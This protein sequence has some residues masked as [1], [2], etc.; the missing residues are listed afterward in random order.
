MESVERT[1]AMTTRRSDISGSS[2]PITPRQ[3]HPTLQPI[4]RKFADRASIALIG[5]RGAGKKS[6]GFITASQLGRRFVNEGLCFE[7]ATGLSKSAYLQ[8]HGKRDFQARSLQVFKRMLQDNEYDCVIDCGM[9]SVA[10]EAQELLRHYA[11]NHPVIHI[12][13]NFDHIAR[14]L[15]LNTQ[16]AKHLK[17]AD[18]R[19]RLCS[20]L[21]FYNVYDSTSIAETEI[22]VHDFKPTSPFVL[23][24]IK[25][26]VQNYV[27]FI[28]NRHS[29]DLSSPFSLSAL[30][31]ELKTRSY[32]TF[33]RL[34]SLIKESAPFDQTDSGEDAVELCI[35]TWRP[36]ITN[37][38]SKWVSML[39]RWLGVRIIVSIVREGLD[40]SKSAH[41]AYCELMN[42]VLRLGVD[43]ITIDMTL[44]E[45]FQT[46][47]L[48]SRGQTKAIAYLHF[49]NH[50]SKTWLDPE[51]VK[52]C[53]EAQRLGY[54]L[55]KLTQFA[56][57][58]QDNHQ[59]LHFATSISQS[60][61][62]P[63]IAY[64]LGYLGRTTKVFNQTLTPI[65]RFEADC[66]SYHEDTPE[67]A[68]W[69]RQICAALFQ[70]FEY[71]PLHFHVIGQ[72]VA[73]SRT[74]A[75][76]NAAFQLYG[77]RHSFSYREVSSFDDVLTFA[78]DPFFGGSAISYPYKE[79][80]FKA[81]VGVSPHASVIGSINTIMPLRQIPANKTDIL[82]EQAA[83]RNRGGTM[84]GL[85]GDNSDWES[86]Y[87]NVRRKLSPRNAAAS[88]KNVGLVL[89]AGGSS[90]STVYALLLLGCTTVY[91][92]NRTRANAV[93]VADHFNAWCRTQESYVGRASVQTL[94]MDNTQWP[95][96]V[97]LPTIIISCVPT[98]STLFG[99]HEKPL[100]IPEAWLGSLAGGVVADVSLLSRPGFSDT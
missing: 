62:I 47:L 24:N 42:H 23:Q 60:L 78:N 88:S 58:R 90:R 82:S 6:L 26:D 61:A 70:C 73:F 71:D 86:I 20:N 84:T 31:P 17:E 1:H 5:V 74:P 41:I 67:A 65:K 64:N 35:D 25:I 55:I 66:T 13:R 50:H 51:R 21:E 59:V 99:R 22:S 48:L 40:A 63:V 15:Q 28:L 81:C 95:Q 98:I 77:M 16:Q 79:L 76:Y 49:E 56:A 54:D 11:L 72:H 38:I 12:V 89:G 91:I 43:Y 39:R 93:R 75:M 52:L 80:A 44:P 92:C 14:H 96:D 29:T 33:Y 69:L 53:H 34:S 30:P 36:D 4:I 18:A 57:E 32:V 85:Y 19:L 10:P 45:M 83:L 27:S 97:N 37:D 9:I 3:A 8:Q 100:E 87:N 94:D 7:E 46:D 68:I 2:S